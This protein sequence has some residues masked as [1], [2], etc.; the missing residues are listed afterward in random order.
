[1]SRSH[2]RMPVWA[3]IIM[4]T[5]L[6]AA[7]VGVFMLFDYVMP[8]SGNSSGT[9]VAQVESNA[10]NTFKLPSAQKG[11]EDNSANEN[12]V[13]NS[14]ESSDVQ[15]ESAAE[16][17]QPA[18]TTAPKQEDKPKRTTKNR[19]DNTG[20]DDYAADTNA[21]SSITNAEVYSE[22]LGHNVTDVSE[23]TVYKKSVGE[24]NDKI[25]Y[26]VADIYVTNAG[27]IQT[28]F[29]ENTY[30]KNIK[31]SV[32]EMAEEHNAIWAINGDFYGNSEEGIVIRNGVKYRDNLNDADICVLFTDGSMKTYAYDEFNTDEVISQ[33]AWQAW[34][35]GPMLLDGSGNVLSSFNT[36]T[37]LNS[38]NPRSAVGYVE[39]GHYIFVTVDGR[40]EGYSKGATISELAAI[41]ADEGCLTAYNLDGGKSAMMY[42]NG[43]IIN[44]PDGGGRDISDIVYIGG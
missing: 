18:V 27:V 33:G 9:V 10:E 34:N 36:T 2:K 16:S 14:S 17:S 30:G 12:T 13:G 42:Y 1:M 38:Q 43:E 4:D 11:G 32:N 44:K 29:A 24:G 20:T 19:Y 41:M 40:M 26:Y 31:S 28:A 15:N 6:M 39:P 35:F 3:M 7:S 5:V 25:T 37:Y 8:H 22:E 21:I 23:L